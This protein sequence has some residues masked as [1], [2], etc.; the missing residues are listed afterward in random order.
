VEGCR[1]GG[2][3]VARPRT[4]IGVGRSVVVLIIFDGRQGWGL[5]KNVSLTV[6]IRK[7][8]ETVTKV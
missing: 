5:K 3:D 6:H 2:R 1:H 4:C 7:I 8:A